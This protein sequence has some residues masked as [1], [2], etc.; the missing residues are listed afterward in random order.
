MAEKMTKKELKEPDA[1]QR[2]GMEATSKLEGKEK[3]LVGGLVALVV[4]GLIAAIV[5]ALSDRSEARAERALGAAMEP[6]G[7][8]VAQGETAQ[9]PNE[10]QPPFASQQ[11]KD[12]AVVES[13]TKFRAEHGGTKSA[14][15]AALPLAQAQLR[16]GKHDDAV[17]SFDQFIKDAAKDNQLRAAALE[18]K[19]YALEA[20]GD[21]DGALAAFDELAKL[22]QPFLQGMGQFHRGRI[23]VLQNKR[24]EA[25][26][27]FA[28]IPEQFPNSAA[29]RQAQERLN[30]LASQGVAVPSPKAPA[31]GGSG[32]SGTVGAAGQK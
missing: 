24:D 26:K 23:L 31:A 7:R 21:L 16:L 10:T 20:K 29:A 15:T 22:E 12:E 8:R 1:L 4:I 30:L 6:V 19:G 2:A 3:Y 27:V 14:T 18:G 32:E 25:A 17:K 13:L 28:S 5:D 9:D 11:A